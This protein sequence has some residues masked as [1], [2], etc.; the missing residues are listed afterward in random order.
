LFKGG[1]GYEVYHLFRF[2]LHLGCGVTE[3]KYWA[4]ILL[5]FATTYVQVVGKQIELLSGFDRLTNLAPY[6]H[7]FG[8]APLLQWLM[9]QIW[10]NNTNCWLRSAVSYFWLACWP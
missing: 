3:W 9:C 10:R 1:C 7:L 5:L 8:G 6:R 4:M 2:S